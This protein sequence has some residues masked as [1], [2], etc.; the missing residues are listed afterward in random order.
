MPKRARWAKNELVEYLSYCYHDKIHPHEIFG[1]YA[2]AFGYGQF[3]P[4][5]FNHYAVDFNGDGKRQPYEWTDVMGSVANYL[6]KNG[7]PANKSG[8]SG[9]DIEKKTYKSVYSYN[10]SDNYV[11]AVLKL[12]EEL[13]KAITLETNNQAD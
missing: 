12:Q 10:H 13:E 3:I 5:S 1:S 2:G 7:Y 9:D 4:S 11:K 8:L 6:V